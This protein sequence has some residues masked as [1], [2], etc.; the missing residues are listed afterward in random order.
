MPDS[1]R[2]IID[3]KMPVRF[4]N[5]DPVLNLFSSEPKLQTKTRRFLE[6]EL[7]CSIYQILRKNGLQREEIL[8]ISAFNST[9]HEIVS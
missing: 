7:T 8:I 2:N 3:P 5:Y 1:L 9:V 6:L 4:V